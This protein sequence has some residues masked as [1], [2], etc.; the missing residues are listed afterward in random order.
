MHFKKKYKINNKPSDKETEVTENKDPQSISIDTYEQQS[1]EANSKKEEE[2]KKETKPVTNNTDNEDNEFKTI[3][4]SDSN[5]K[6]SAA[7]NEEPLRPGT[8]EQPVAGNKA[9]ELRT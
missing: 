8:G 5:S 6:N 7:D 3:D 9:D 4:A 1:L 2:S